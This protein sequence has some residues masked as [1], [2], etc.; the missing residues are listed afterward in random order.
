MSAKHDT[1][2]GRRVVARHDVGGLEDGA[3]KAF[4]VG[5]LG[6]YLTS[7]LLKF[8]D[9]PIQASLVSGGV[10]GPWAKIALRLD[11]RESRV[12]I[13]LRSDRLYLF[14]FLGIISSAGRA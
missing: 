12:G 3:I 7:I 4:E 8:S 2:G 13:K 11:K 5:L 10:H 14:R 6:F 9:D 1:R